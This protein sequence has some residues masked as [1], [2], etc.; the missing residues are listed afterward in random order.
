MKNILKIIGEVIV[1]IGF[2]YGLVRT[3]VI[4]NQTAITIG[5]LVVVF[6]LS[7]EELKKE[8]APIKNALCEIQ[9]YLGEKWKFVPMHEIKP[10]GFVQ[11]LSPITLTP[12]GTDLL[13][14]S[15]AKK[16]ID[17]DIENWLKLIDNNKPKTALD[18]QSNTSKIIA[19]KADENIMSVVKVFVYKNPNFGDTPLNFADVQRVMV[20]YLRDL[21]LERHPEIIQ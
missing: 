17:N 13:E 1:F 10:A 4:N 21:Y 3:S 15:E 8:F 18:V 19:E 6:I 14:K 9:K 20:V 5:V 7:F 2:L 11:L 16:V 12:A